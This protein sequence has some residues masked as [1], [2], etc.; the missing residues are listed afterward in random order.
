AT[1]NAMSERDRGLMVANVVHVDSLTI[2][3]IVGTNAKSTGN[4]Q[5]IEGSDLSRRQIGSLSVQDIDV[6]DQKDG[7]RTT[8]KSLEVRDVPTDAWFD[9]ALTGKQA[10]G[11][12]QVGC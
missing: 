12:L 3:K 4:V 5:R 10:T 7:T 6:K 1:I 9:Y 2:D 11:M 8:W